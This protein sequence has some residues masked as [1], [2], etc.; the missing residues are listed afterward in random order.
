MN[1][2]FSVLNKNGCRQGLYSFPIE[3]FIDEK[4]SLQALQEFWI[5]VE[6][7]IL[8]IGKWFN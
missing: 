6:T 7:M 4:S 3:R 8:L 5:S 1:F 2:K